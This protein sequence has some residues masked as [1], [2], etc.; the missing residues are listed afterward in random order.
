[1]ISVIVLIGILFTQN[2]YSSTNLSLSMDGPKT[3]YE[4]DQIEYSLVVSN[5]GTTSIE[6]GEVLV[7]LPTTL[8]FADSI[9]TP[10]GI[11]DPASGIWSL[12][13]LGTE[14]ISKTA[15]L[16]IQAIV[17]ADLIPDPGEFVTSINMAEVIS[18]VFPETIQAEVRTN[19]VCAFCIDWVFSS[20]GLGYEDKWD[21]DKYKSNFLFYVN[22]VNNGPV[23]SEARVSNTYFNIS[24]GGYGTVSLSPS[25]P[26]AVNIDT[27]DT[28]QI[29]Y[30]TGWID[31]PDSDY[32]LT[33]EFAISDVALLDPVLP[34][35]ASGS[36]NGD[37]EGSPGGG[38]GGCTISTQNIFDPLWI[39]L[40]IL[41]GLYHLENKLRTRYCFAPVVVR[42]VQHLK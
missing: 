1:M 14:E 41:F 21:D 40:S 13:S 18:P 3:A 30:S 5:I 19:I 38:G 31:G 9:P 29:I 16:L 17:R 37:V 2:A 11:Y 26:V 10:G 39:L 12:P 15:G 42:M 8:D 33:W 6:G 36:W 27:G 25:E 7:K 4:G 20:V 32:E 28:Q 22:I 34:N 35:T 24:G 23:K